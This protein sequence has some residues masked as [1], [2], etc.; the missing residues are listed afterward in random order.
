MPA[1]VGMVLHGEQVVAEPVGQTSRLEHALRV[2]G[3][4]AQEVAELDLVA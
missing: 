2:A 3:V 1:L 4:R